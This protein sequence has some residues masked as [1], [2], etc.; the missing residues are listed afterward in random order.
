VERESMI[1]STIK[2]FPCIY[3]IMI[4]DTEIDHVSILT[5]LSL[6]VWLKKRR[7]IYTKS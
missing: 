1:Q 7:N 4:G 2:P 3:N 6:F 5:I